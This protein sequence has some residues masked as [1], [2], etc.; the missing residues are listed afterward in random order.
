LS[1]DLFI[2]F[3]LLLGNFFFDFLPFENLLVKSLFDLLLFFE[4][5][6]AFFVFAFIIQNFG[7]TGDLT[8][9]VGADLRGNIVIVSILP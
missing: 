1:D 4:I 8:P 3:N 9:L 5:V 6:I 7:V 2:V